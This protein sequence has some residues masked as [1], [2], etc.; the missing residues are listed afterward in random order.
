MLHLTQGWKAGSCGSGTHSG[1]LLGMWLQCELFIQTAEQAETVPTEEKC[2]H[3]HAQR[4]NG[5]PAA[6]CMHA[7]IL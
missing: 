7:C 3:R 6:E 5:I 2:R 1:W 4:Q